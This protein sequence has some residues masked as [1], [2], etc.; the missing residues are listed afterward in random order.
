M[1]LSMYTTFTY[2]LRHHYPREHK[3]KRQKTKKNFDNHFVWMIVKIEKILRKI[4]CEN[5]LRSFLEE[6]YI[7]LDILLTS[8]RANRN[9]IMEIINN[10]LTKCGRK[11]G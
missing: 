11:R 10:N 6:I 2:S 1:R 7:Y 9:T 4:S 5:I 8:K 3:R